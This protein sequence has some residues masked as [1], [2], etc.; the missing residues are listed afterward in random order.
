MEG[1]I[2]VKVPMP[3]PE[4]TAASDTVTSNCRK[5]SFKPIINLKKPCSDPKLI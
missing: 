4:Q 3:L 1:L 5:I 2:T